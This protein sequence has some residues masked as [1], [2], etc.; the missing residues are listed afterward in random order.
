[1]VLRDRAG[2]GCG[3]FF[4]HRCRMASSICARQAKAAPAVATGL[5]ARGGRSARRSGPRSGRRSDD[6]ARV[7]EV[8]P[9][10]VALARPGFLHGRVACRARLHRP[11]FGELAGRHPLAQCHALLRADPHPAHGGPDRDRCDR[12][13]GA[14]RRRTRG[15]H[16]RLEGQAKA[17]PV[18]NR[19]GLLSSQASGHAA[20][21]RSISTAFAAGTATMRLISSA[22]R[23]K[24][25]RFSPMRSS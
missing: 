15:P 7:S 9:E 18:I 22:S 23:C 2:F 6:V 4:D 24:A 13:P 3:W 11:I 8:V 12:S 17:R 21:R 1:M 10:R 16:R 19:G 14:A 25:S 20:R 5:R